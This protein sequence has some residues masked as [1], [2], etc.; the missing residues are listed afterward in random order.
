MNTKE[1]IKAMQFMHDELASCK[2]WKDVLSHAIEVMKA[3]EWQPI[4]SAPIGEDILLG[5]QDYTCAGWVNP[6]M[7][8]NA[9]QGVM[10]KQPTHWIP[11]PQPP[12]GEE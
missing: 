4:E 3:S 12:Q 10:V 9:G 1:A 5:H 6:F 8:A 11:L 2:D 7:K